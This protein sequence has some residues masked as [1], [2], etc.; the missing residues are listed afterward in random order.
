MVETHAT[1]IKR[2]SFVSF[3]LRLKKMKAVVGTQT[4]G[5]VFNFR[6]INSIAASINVKVAWLR[7]RLSSHFAQKENCLTLFPLGCYTLQ[8]PTKKIQ[9]TFTLQMV[10]K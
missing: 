3:S 7:H 1:E 10:N 9:I 6:F 8:D 2:V 4:D 5:L